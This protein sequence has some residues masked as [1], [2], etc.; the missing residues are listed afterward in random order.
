M[1][2][3][4]LWDLRPKVRERRFKWTSGG[5]NKSQCNNKDDPLEVRPSMH[6]IMSAKILFIVFLV[7]LKLSELSCIKGLDRIREDYCEL[8]CDGSCDNR[9][10]NIQNRILTTED[11][12]MKL[13]LSVLQFTWTNRI[14]EGWNIYK[15]SN[16]TNCEILKLVVTGIPSANDTRFRPS[17]HYL[18]LLG[19][20]ETIKFEINVPSITIT[21]DGIKDILGA[22]EL[23]FKY[24]NDNSVNSFVINNYIR[25]SLNN[26]MKIHIIAST[27]VKPTFRIEKNIF[28]G[29]KDLQILVF[30]GLNVE[31]LTAET[32]DG[33]TS[34][35]QLNI[36]GDVKNFEFLR[37]ATLRSS[38]KYCTMLVHGMVDLKNFDHF[39]KLE[40]IMVFQYKALKNL[41]AYVC[42]PTQNECDF[43]LGINGIPCPPKCR[44][45]YSQDEM[46]FAIDCSQQDHYLIPALPIP[47]KGKTVLVL[48]QN[49]LSQLPDR[50]LEGYNNL[51]GLDVSQNQLTSLSTNRLPQDLDY[52]DISF[53]HISTLSQDVLAYVRNLKY[54]KQFGN[55]WIIYNDETHLLDY[56]LDNAKWL[57]IKDSKFRFVMEIMNVT[58][59]AAYLS[60]FFKLDHTQFYWEANEDYIIN[61]FRQSEI[62]ITLKLMEDLNSAI[63]MLS[64]EYD[65]YIFHHLNELCPYRCTCCVERQTDQFIIN[66]TNAYL[67]YFPRLPHLIPY[68]TT[69]YLDGNEINKLTSPQNIYI[70]GLASIQKWHMSGNMLAE[71]PHHLMPENITYLDIRN[72]ALRILDD[73]LVEFL[74]YRK[75]ITKVKLSGNPWDFDCKAKNFLSFLRE[76]DPVEYETVM[77]RVNIT[78]DKC[79]EECICCIDS[80]KYKPLSLIVDCSNKGLG[81]VPP[82]PT[83]T[84]GQ[85]TLIFERNTLKEWPS[86]SLP[87]YSSV[88][89]FY[90][91]HNQLSNIDQLPGNVNHL[92]IS[93]NNFSVL[94]VRVRGFL[95]KRMNS[96]QLK[97]VLSGNPWTCSCEEKDF[98][99]FVKEQAKNI[100]N[101][102][103]VQCGKTGKSL[104]EVE[105]ID[106]CPSVLIYYTSF[107]IS[108]LIIAVSIN[109]FICF[110]QPILIWFYEHEI[111]L[112]LAARRELD[113][114]KK[115]DA[116]LSFTHKDE[117]LIGEF[118]DRLEKGRHKFRLCFYLR[119]WLV[120]ESIP[121]CINQ[122]VKDSKRIII[123]MT[124]NFLKSTWGRLE[125]RLAL[126]ATSKDRCKRLIVVLYPD[127]ENFDDLDSELR[128][129]MVLNTYL[130]RNHPNFWNKLIYSM[131]HIMLREHMLRNPSNLETK[132]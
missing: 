3:S 32:F 31:G 130:E 45:K 9:T 107:A 62:Y 114:D 69:L 127:V 4:K 12:Q 74:R 35:Y 103:A 96:S 49:Q 50:S 83:P 42:F 5:N 112:S 48:Q 76:R 40:I 20:N 89:R 113:Q 93:Y 101:A 131:P 123:L 65:G 33:L 34:L 124:K 70:A 92:D 44:C 128:A 13:Y 66:C 38:L 117:D 129:Y 75:E 126:H 115:F 78:Q 43:T 61:A 59:K 51:K 73:E 30:S 98:L 22:E 88:A 19:I 119:D 26:T 11:Y 27:S 94:S 23:N 90:L 118:V 100:G 84:I 2:H 6:R 108:L 121:D 10:C 80:P 125:F 120:G 60:Y 79:P 39:P 17:A 28:E 55:K 47:I 109:I 104:L 85:T 41:T 81:Q 63:W 116:F 77:R 21:E 14:F 29:K 99:L 110:R 58:S 1:E 36:D 8:Y 54:F 16:E 91:A 72:N 95:Q 18:R 87:G 86:S 122:S 97:L 82:L 64:G 57:R 7:I 111:C 67:D 102:S 132:L 15:I 52:L 53:N 24:L 37:S 25:E 68:N 106:I 46:I 71:L 105:E 56:F